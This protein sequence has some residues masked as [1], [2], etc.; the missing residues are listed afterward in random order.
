M[1]LND[2]ELGKEY[3]IADVNTDG[4]YT[5]DTEAIKGGYFH[6]SEY[7]SAPYFD[8]LIDGISFP[9]EDTDSG[10]ST[11]RRFSTFS[12]KKGLSGGGIVAIVL[13]M[14]AAVITVGG[15]LGYSTLGKTS[16][17][18]APIENTAT[19]LNQFVK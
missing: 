11:I 17:A 4:N 14:A 12:K 19:S 13:P 2:A 15:L 3:I 9:E 6:E 1:N 10:N 7:R 8:L 18:K 16:A 5:G